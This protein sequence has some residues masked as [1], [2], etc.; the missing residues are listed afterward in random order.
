[1]WT[2]ASQSL[3][4]QGRQKALFAAFPGECFPGVLEVAAASASMAV[5]GHWRPFRLQFTLGDQRRHWDTAGASSRNG[6]QASKQI[7]LQF[8][9]S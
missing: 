5:S 1:M 9:E 7:L 3:L 8:R 4:P 2:T 6:A